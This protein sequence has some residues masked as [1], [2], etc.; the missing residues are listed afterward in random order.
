MPL[1]RTIF[2]I[3]DDRK[4]LNLL[5]ATL[6]LKDFSVV[7]MEDPVQ[8]L[9]YLKENVPDLILA[10][11][12]LDGADGYDFFRRVRETTRAA[13]TP[14]ILLGGA[15]A[16][17][18]QAARGLRMGA[19]EFLRKPFSI[20]ELLVR[21][22][23]V[24]E[25]VD[26]SRTARPRSDL[27]GRLEHWRIAD[28]L[29]FLGQRR[30]SGRLTVSL[31]ADPVEGFLV[32]QD[33]HVRHAVF[34]LLKGATALLQLLPRA[35]G[36]FSF[37]VTEAR[38]IPVVTIPGDTGPILEKGRDMQ[39]EGRLRRV[40]VTNR[41]ACRLFEAL[42]QDGA[43]EPLQLE[44]GVILLTER[45]EGADETE[46]IEMP[47]EEAIAA[48]AEADAAAGGA[49]VAAPP[50]PVDGGE[51]GAS[52]SLADEAPAG[53]SA[54]MSVSED[55]DDGPP[56]GPASLAGPVSGAVGSGDDEFE[57]EAPSAGGEPGDYGNPVPDTGE[58][59][60][61][62]AE[63]ATRSA[64]M[65]PADRLYGDDDGLDS[66]GELHGL[67]GDAMATSSIIISAR[68]PEDVAVSADLDDD[69]D[70]DG[71]GEQLRTSV[72][73]EDTGVAL[74]DRGPGPVEQLFVL[75]RD[76]LVGEVAGFGLRDVL[77]ATR[78]GRPLA[79]TLEDQDRKE[80]VAAFAAQAIQF[81]PETGLGTYAELSA[82]DLHLVVVE[83]PYRRLLA[84]VFDNPPDAAKLMRR[85]NELI[86]QLD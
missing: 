15:D 11:V 69:G 71:E 41:D 19:E 72:D 50:G 49:P 82:S 9:G 2:I 7:K 65:V 5:E 3:D 44:D 81:A 14:F 51:G 53:A 43:E 79:A 39:H 59:L 45:V 25:K 27:E 8:A 40:D 57:F 80:H 70:L 6:R 31:T 23:K 46:T 84:C 55:L 83:L 29:E 68:R 56:A 52:A 22:E 77:I 78:S 36:A 34:G 16:D 66:G 48:V 54:S 62:E 21:V 35:R 67:E 32:L 1:Q 64:M 37:A 42:V 75:L 74:V 20:D 17:P 76:E 58:S 85:I 33:G 10:G 86:A 26:R 18:V 13:Y 73:G 38:S 24:F 28:V 61:I 60:V 47:V 63:E 30:A 4:V 12:H